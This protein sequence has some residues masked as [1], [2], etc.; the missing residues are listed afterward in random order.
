MFS[1]INEDFPL[2]L[3]EHKASLSLYGIGMLLNRIQV[4]SMTLVKYHPK[5]TQFSINH[6]LKRNTMHISVVISL[7]STASCPSYSIF[8]H[9]DLQFFLFKS[10]RPLTFA[11]TL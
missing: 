11:W 7:Y 8:R 9:L 6:R 3:V 2:S 4:D 5:Y 10:P 1:V